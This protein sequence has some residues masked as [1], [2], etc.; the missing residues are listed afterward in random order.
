M[1]PQE[2]HR[3]EAFELQCSPSKSDVDTRRKQCCEQRHKH[4]EEKNFNGPKLLNGV[5]GDGRQAEDI[6]R[7]GGSRE[8]GNY[9]K[10]F[11]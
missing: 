6:N 1:I 7:S 10:L 11:S 9:R 3:F 4:E 2:D 8:V 5:C